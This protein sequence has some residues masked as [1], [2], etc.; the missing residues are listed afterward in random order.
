MDANNL[1]TTVNTPYANYYIVLLTLVYT[2]MITP[3]K[4]Y[5]VHPTTTLIKSKENI[6][7]SSLKMAVRANDTSAH[8][9]RSVAPKRVVEQIKSILEKECET[10]STSVLYTCAAAI[11]DSMERVV[12]GQPS[13]EA[14]TR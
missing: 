5:L 9:F 12:H 11:L 13:N 1:H 14:E 10:T 6:P 2:T 8:F 3:E 7:A 4:C